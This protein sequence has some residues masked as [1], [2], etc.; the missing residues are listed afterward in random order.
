MTTIRYAVYREGPGD[1]STYAECWGSTASSRGH[2]IGEYRDREEALQ[3][4]KLESDGDSDGGASVT[5]RDRI[6]HEYIDFSR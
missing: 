3:A 4:A 6:A 5:V 1:G 2:L